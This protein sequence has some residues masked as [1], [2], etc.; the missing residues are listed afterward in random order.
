LRKD[1][2]QL[3]QGGTRKKCKICR[4]IFHRRNGCPQA[5]KEPPTNPQTQPPT[6]SSQQTQPPT[7]G[8]GTEQSIHTPTK[9]TIDTPI[10][11]P[12]KALPGSHASSGPHQ[13][14]QQPSTITNRT[15]QI[16]P[17]ATQQSQAP[18]ART[19]LRPKLAYK[20]GGPTWK[21]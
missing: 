11:S 10:H 19:N 6:G 15:T 17:G 7:H 12:T 1:S 4:Q 20:S 9:A 3:R 16:E 5:L 18:P 21:P 2:T 13:P 8:P 14:I